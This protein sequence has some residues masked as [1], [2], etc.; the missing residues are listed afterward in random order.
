MQDR[1]VVVGVDGTNPALRAVAWAATQARLRQRPL[2]IV[3]AVTCPAGSS[4]PGD[5]ATRPDTD[6]ILGRARTL[7]DQGGPGLATRTLLACDRPTS[8]LTEA[9]RSA[10]LLVVGM[11]GDR[12]PE[13][14]L[15]SVAL[16]LATG[17]H[18][19]VTV[20]RRHRSE[21]TSGPVLLG[22]DGVELDAAAV[23]VAFDDAA[24]HHS[25]LVVLHV[26]PGSHPERSVWPEAAVAELADL[27]RLLAPWQADHPEVPVETRVGYGNPTIAV[28]RTA[29]TAR[30][31]VLGSHGRGPAA[32]KVLGS[33]SSFV[34]H[35]SACPV[36]IVPP[37]LS[38]AAVGDAQGPPQ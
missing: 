23:T 32:R 5:A 8:A 21:A 33:V 4:G 19:P 25:R 3:H 35:R 13:I 18:C 1:P 2:H 37:A 24:R 22:V 26:A 31:V 9:S 6:A 20:V 11:I 36:T 38:V 7:A 28:L 15:G 27:R 16:G 17:A 14:D 10:D 12:E 29:S 34:L 30:H